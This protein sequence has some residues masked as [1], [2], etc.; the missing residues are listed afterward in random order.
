MD[1][2]EEKISLC[3]D[4]NRVMELI[5]EMLDLFKENPSMHLVESVRNAAENMKQDYF[6]GKDAQA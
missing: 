2:F 1:K 5:I 3:E 4:K 6:G